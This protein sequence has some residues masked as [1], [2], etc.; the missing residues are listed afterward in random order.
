MID[1]VYISE[2]ASFNRCLN[3]ENLMTENINKV[4]NSLNW[5]GENFIFKLV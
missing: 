1:I 5:I 2:S 3:F 4:E